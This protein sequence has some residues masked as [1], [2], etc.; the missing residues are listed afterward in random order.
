MTNTR[1]SRAGLPAAEGVRWTSGGSGDFEVEAI[2]RAA[3]GTSVI[4]HLREDKTEYLNHWKLKSIIERYSDHISLPIRMQAEQW[5]AEKSEYVLKDEWETINS[6]NALWSRPKK[7]VS[8]EQYTEFYKTLSH[9]SE[10]PLAWSQN[11]VEGSTEYTQLLYI[12]ASAPH[13]LWNRERK[14]G[15]EAAVRK[16][17][18]ALKRIEAT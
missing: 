11:R 5:D 2:E 13:D 12:P 14:A 9:D 4:L 8:D 7:D 17:Q 6:A 16:L 10:A 3:R 15:F 18:A 1:W